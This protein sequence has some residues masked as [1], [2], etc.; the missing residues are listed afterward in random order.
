MYLQYFWEVGTS[1][2]TRIS[3]QKSSKKR[4]CNPNVILNCS[5]QKKYEKVMQKGRQ[6]FPPYPS[7]QKSLLP[8]E[9]PG[10]RPAPWSSPLGDRNLM[11]IPLPSHDP[12]IPDIGNQMLPKTSKMTPKSDPKTKKLDF[13]KRVFYRSKTL[14]FEVTTPS[15]PTA[16]TSQG[17]W[18]AFWHYKYEKVRQLAPKWLPMDLLQGSKIHWISSKNR[19][20]LPKGSLWSA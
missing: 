17:I 20:R 19:L 14:L 12:K 2:F 3:I 13:P 7:H 6:W 15:K 9:N 4:D 18:S 11:R 10:N 1:E 8:G 16:E 5:N